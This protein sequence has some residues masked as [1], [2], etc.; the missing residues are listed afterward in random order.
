MSRRRR[1]G[2]APLRPPLKRVCAG[3]WKSHDGEW[4]FCRHQSDPQPQRWFAYQGDDD[5]PAN[6]GSGHTR[7]ADAATWALGDD[8]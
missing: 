2:T 6:D 7:L 5:Y 3:V 4:T 1:Y 8:R